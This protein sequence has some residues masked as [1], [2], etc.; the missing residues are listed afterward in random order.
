MAYENLLRS[1]EESAQ[2]KEQEIK[3]KAGQLAEK[4]CTEAAKEADAIRV[5]AVREAERS[6][7]IERNRQLFLARG[8]IRQ[9]ALNSREEIFAAAFDAAERQL[10]QL[11][12]SSA[13]PEVFARL[14][15]EATGAMQG[16]VFQVHIDP[17][18]RDLCAKTLA[19]PGSR[20]EVLTDIESAGGLVISSPDGRVVIA[21]T[22][23]SRLARAR[24]KKRFEVYA[25]LFG[26]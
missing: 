3:R 15:H 6:A 10:S 7:A 4:I 18:D 11:R 9:R 14:T 8:E 1:V 24:E 2:E 26:G 22:I 12:E 19:T 17:R 21:N 25:A 13:Y 20:Y 23:E 5:R 16:E